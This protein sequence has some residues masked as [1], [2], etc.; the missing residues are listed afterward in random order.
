MHFSCISN[1]HEILSW[2]GLQTQSGHIGLRFFHA[3]C[4]VSSANFYCVFVLCVLRIKVFASVSEIHQ[5]K[6][7]KR[8]TYINFLPLRNFLGHP[9]LYPVLVSALWLKLYPG[10]FWG[11]LWYQRLNPLSH[12]DG[13][14]S[15]CWT[16]S[17]AC[18]IFEFTIQ[19]TSCPDS[20]FYPTRQ[21]SEY[22]FSKLIKK[23]L[24][25]LE[26]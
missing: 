7:R 9:Q 12:I 14:C 20:S 3:V 21:K 5:F 22:I 6:T 4:L 11:N 1:N 26:W 16:I 19:R 24:V 2:A 25:G 13:L 23:I 15:S 17:L 10:F 18:F 8:K